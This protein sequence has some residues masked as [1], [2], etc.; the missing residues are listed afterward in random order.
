[1]VRPH[2]KKAALPASGGRR[3]GL[4]AEASGARAAI[5][6]EYSAN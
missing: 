3:T 2:R 6:G 4:M 1:L 5:L